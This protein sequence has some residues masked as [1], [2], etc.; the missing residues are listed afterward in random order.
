MEVRVARKRL[1]KG[2]DLLISG[3]GAG[4]EEEVLNVRIGEIRPNPYQ[5]RKAVD[6]EADRELADSIKRN[7]LLQPV[8]VRRSE[9]GYELI[10]G[11]RR[12]RAGKSI[13][14]E[15]IPAVVK[16][17]SDKKMMEL[18]LV[19]NIQRKDLNPIELAVAYREMMEKTGITQE[20]LAS[21]V[22]KSRAA[23]ANHVRL[24]TLPAEVQE[25]VSRGTIT[26]GHAKSILS[27]KTEAERLAMLKAILDSGMNVRHAEEKARK[28]LKRPGQQF[29]GPLMT[30]LEENLMKVLGTK[31]RIKP[32][33]KGG[34]ILIDYYSNEDFERIIELFGVQ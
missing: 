1:G 21:R 24:L 31:V 10:A 8:V 23:V 4:P 22:G 26:M 27:L 14:L 32:T 30:E 5:P 18:A 12:W 20:D 28:A 3:I 25:N 15:N 33:S 17:V 6:E 29:S 11:E 19:E 16:Q 9:G 34:R 13:G 2:L 7:G